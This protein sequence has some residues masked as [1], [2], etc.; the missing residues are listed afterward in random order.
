MFYDL[1]NLQFHDREILQG[2]LEHHE[3]GVVIRRYMEEIVRLPGEHLQT[4]HPTPDQAPSQPN[5]TENIPAPTVSSLPET[6]SDVQEPVP[7]FL[8]APRF[9]PDG[10][11]PN[12][13]VC[14]LDPTSSEASASVPAPTF[15]RAP[16]MASARLSSKVPAPTASSA[17]ETVSAQPVSSTPETV[18]A[19]T[20]S[21]APETVP[22]QTV[23]SAPE[24][25]PGQ[26]V[27]SAPKTIPA[28]TVSSTPETVP[29][30]TVSSAP[31]TLPDPTAPNAPKTLPAPTWRNTS[32]K[33][34]AKSSCEPKTGP[35]RTS[36]DA[37]ITSGLRS[38]SI[39]VVA[40]AS[41]PGSYTL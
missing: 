13:Q 18:P 14:V 37:Q 21:S 38:L 32:E 6:W 23:S 11:I 5:T 22:G 3:G 16:V 30:Q 31:E 39:G 33:F 20:A 15:F 27:S 10:S 29:G 26:T 17:P 25:V 2:Q 40:S 24:T 7:P 9:V 12:A 8:S 41:S 19:P 34:P 28:P 4:S 1:Y 35:V 36:G